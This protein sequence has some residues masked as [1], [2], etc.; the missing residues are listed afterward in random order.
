MT[1]FSERSITLTVPL[2]AIGVVWVL[3]WFDI[4]VSI[5]VLIGLILLAGIVVNNAIVL[6]DRIN[7]NRERGLRLREAV[8]E[9][10]QT[11]L[12]P[13]LMTA[14]A[15]VM[16]LLPM[17]GWLEAVPWI[18]SLGAGQGAEIRAPMAIT[19]IA[20]LA[21]STALT[22]IVIPVLYTASEAWLENR[23][24]NEEPA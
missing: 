10:G 7:Q 14:T 22:L 12:R 6:V 5:V 13:I 9:A 17:T 1:L 18:G 4:P 21:V 20:G 11:R 19:V 8:F 24:T 2:A 16:G 23:A 3:L 15:S